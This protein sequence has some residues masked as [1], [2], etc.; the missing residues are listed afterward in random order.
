[1]RHRNADTKLS[2]TSA[3]RLALFRNLT[4]SL[5]LHGKV[6]TTLAKAKACRPFAERLITRAKGGTLHDR[7]L[8]AARLRHVEAERKLFGEVADRFRARQG[9]YTAI[10]RLEKN[11]LRD[12]AP[13]VIFELVAWEPGEKPKAKR[14]KKAAP[15]DRARK[16]AK[17]PE[18]AGKPEAEGGDAKPEAKAPAPAAPKAAE[19]PA[20]KK[21]EP[22]AK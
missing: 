11:R 1:M 9:G 17:A 19:A 13:M 5:L 22:K 15:K 14:R 8:V 3:H 2:R 12:D 21:D 18:A 7:R 10:H 16:D 4:A 20:S 6:V